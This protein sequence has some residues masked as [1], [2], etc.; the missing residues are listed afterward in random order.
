MEAGFRETRF[1]TYKKSVKTEL[2]IMSHTKEIEFSQ[3]IWQKFETG[4]KNN[5][6]GIANDRKR[7]LCDGVQMQNVICKLS[8]FL[9]AAL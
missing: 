5:D 6:D 3:S 7:L 1:M 4:G 9:F 2:E 8:C